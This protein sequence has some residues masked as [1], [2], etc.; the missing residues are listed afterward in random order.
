MEEAVVGGLALVGDAVL[1][2]EAGMAME[3]LELLAGEQ[4]GAALRGLGDGR[5]VSGD[6]AVV[7][8]VAR[9][10]AALEAGDR[11][12][13][14]MQGDRVGLVGEG[15]AEQRVVARHVV[16]TDEQLVLHAA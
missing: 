2:V 11:A 10:Q 16:Q 6:K 1:E 4:L 14:V 13:D 15:G 3:A 8:R 5:D 7:R 12:G 9:E